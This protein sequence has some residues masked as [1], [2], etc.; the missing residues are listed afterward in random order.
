MAPTACLEMATGGTEGQ[1]LSPKRR[2]N[3]SVEVKRLLSVLRRTVKESTKTTTKD[4]RT[5]R[6][7]NSKGV[8]VLLGMLVNHVSPSG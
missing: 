1:T 6:F 2:T 4:A 8:L 3:L 7:C 5:T